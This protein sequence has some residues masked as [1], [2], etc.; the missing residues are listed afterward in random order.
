MN[1]IELMLSGRIEMEEFIALLN[2]S[3]QLQD[4]LRNLVPPEAKNNRAHGLWRK[5]SY[6]AIAG[7]DFDLYRYLKKT[8]RFSGD[9]ADNLNI[10]GCISAIYINLHPDFPFT[11]R[12]HDAF[13]LYLD[14][15]KDCYDGIAV[16]ALVMKV[17]QDALVVRT[18]KGRRE[19]ANNM[20]R[21]LFH[22]EKHNR[23]YWIQGPEWPMGQKTPMRYLRRKSHGEKV[24]YFFEDVDTG[25]IRVVVQYY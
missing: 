19:Q 20:I 5:Y 2:V 1:S 24:E 7:A 25:D 4:D 14:V 8:F 23:P 13:G 17:I 16:R 9:I 3:S 18:K 12:Y 15:I 21:E 22:V 6:D 10:F 11:T